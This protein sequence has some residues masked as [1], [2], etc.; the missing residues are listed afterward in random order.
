MNTSREVVVKLLKE[1]V[2]NETF[3]VGQVITAKD[4][5]SHLPAGIYPA[6]AGVVINRVAEAGLLKALGDRRL[7]VTEDLRETPIQDCIDL[8]SQ[9]GRERSKANGDRKKRQIVNVQ[10]TPVVEP[11]PEEQQT[12]TGEPIGYLTIW[13]FVHALRT[14]QIREARFALDEE[15]SARATSAE[16]NLDVV[17]EELRRILKELDELQK[18]YETLREELKV[19]RMRTLALREE[20]NKL[21]VMPAEKIAQ[22]EV[23]VKY[24]KEQG[25]QW[26]SSQ[27]RPGEV[28]VHPKPPTRHTPRTILT[29]RIK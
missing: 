6:A 4:I 27:A 7:E 29:T 21:R 14:E 17:Q 22:E 23:R 12:E 3:K 25:G 8:V 5:I 18:K 1:L 24:R 10:A 26:G 15:E 9:A 20:N 19:E 28:V 16:G 13:E 2:G 11:E